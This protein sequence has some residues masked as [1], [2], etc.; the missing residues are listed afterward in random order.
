[1]PHT[2]EEVQQMLS[3][4]GISSVDELF[5]AIPEDLRS[6]LPGEIGAPFDELKL[7]KLMKEIS[8]TNINFTEG[9]T[10]IGAGAY[11]HYIPSVISYLVKRGEFL[12][13]YT[14]YQ[15]EVAQGTLQSM[16]EFQT[17]MCELTGMEVANASNYDLSTACAEALLM[18]KRIN[19]KSKFLISR[20]THPQYRSVIQTY[21]ANQG[22]ELVEI[23]F[24]T[25]GRVDT[26]FIKDNLDES[27]S[28]VLI[29]SPNFFGVVE[30]LAPIGAMIAD[31]KSLF[32]VANS[33]SLSY[34]VLKSPAEVGADIAVAEGMSLGI[35][36]NYGGPY[37]GVFATKQ[38]YIRNM[39]GRIVGETVDQDGKRGYALTFAAREQHIRR[40]KATS[41]I[42]T[43][44]GL[45]AL[46][47]AVYLSL[48]GPEGNEKIAL[49][50][51]QRIRQ[52]EK[53]L[54]VSNPNAVY[55]DGPKF[56]ESVIKL[57][58]PAKEAVVHLLQDKI[59]A[60]VDLSTYYPEL[61]HHLLVCTTEMC[62]AVDVEV[63]AERLSRYL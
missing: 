24:N 38:K 27:V 45:C 43:N 52:L 40:E 60:G 36:M 46:M 39:P 8:E 51:L 34:A 18:A 28:A 42:C 62:S 55:F 56:N 9:L 1:M 61:T 14:P 12:T 50:N 32:V 2:N 30:D 54:S 31:S 37:L 53:S 13:A 19:G 57:N 10:F 3:T 11:Y 59:L 16:F 6:S 25:Q 44:Q 5:L 17:M 33:E 35:G 29:Q 41:N 63:F 49:L 58:V 4:I 15:A 48:M 23:P 26:D 21:F 7:K 20:S 47:C 22:C